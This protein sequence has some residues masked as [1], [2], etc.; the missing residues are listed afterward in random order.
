MRA[1]EWTL[2]YDGQCRFCARCVALLARWDRRHRV[3]AVAFQDRGALRRLPPIPRATLEAAMQ[4]V[5]PDGNVASGAAAAP[6]LLRLLPGGRPVAA[7]FDMPGASHLAAAVYRW[8]A[9]HRH[10]LPCG[11][12]VCRRGAA[13]QG[14]AT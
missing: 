1:R 5:G 14:S 4:L 8:V 3:A 9:R 7:L 11:S 10:R 13:K 6:L 2:V 12:P